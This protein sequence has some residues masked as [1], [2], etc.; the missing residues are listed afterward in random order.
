MLIKVFKHAGSSLSVPHPWQA[1]LRVVPVL[2]LSVAEAVLSQTHMCCLHLPTGC[3]LML[4]V[5]LWH[6]S[7]RHGEVA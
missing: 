1:T 7:S 6:E 4:Q 2:E 5:L 3:C